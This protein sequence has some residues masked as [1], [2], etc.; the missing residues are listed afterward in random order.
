MYKAPDKMAERIFHL[1]L[2]ILFWITG[3]DYTVVKK[4]S[5]DQCQAFVS[6][7]RGGT[8]SPIPG[9]P[10]HPRIHEDINDRKILELTY[11][12]I[13]L[14]TGE[15]PIRCQDV[16]VY[17][18][19]EEWDYLEGHKDL[20]KDVMMEVPQ[21]RTSPVLSSERT[22]PERC[23]RP[24]LPLDHQDE[25]LNHNNAPDIIIKVEDMDVWGEEWCKEGIPTDNRFD[26]LTTISEKHLISTNFKEEDSDITQY[27][28][29]EHG[30]FSHETSALHN[31]DLQSKALGQVLSSHLSQTVKEKETRIV[32]SQRSHKGEKP[33]VCSECGKCFRHKSYLVIHERIHT[34]EKPYSCLE[35]GK[36]FIQ[37]SHLDKH[38]KSHTGEKPFLCSECGKCFNHKTNLVLH[39][40]IHTGEK[41][42]SCLECGKCFTDQSNLG[43]HQRSHKGEKPY[44]C[45]E[46]SKCF[47]QKSDLL[48]HQR[49]HTGEKPFSCPECGKCFT[50]QSNLIKHERGH[51]EVKPFSCSQCGKYFNQKAHY[52]IHERSHTGEKPFSCSECGK[53]FNQKSHLTTHQRSHTGEKPFSCSECG[54]CFTR[55][56]IL[57]KH[58]KIHMGKYSL[59]N[60]IFLTDPSGMDKDRDKIAERILQLTLEILF[61][62][63]GEDYTV[64]KKNSSDRCQAPVCEGWRG[65]MS[66]IPGSPPHPQIHEV[67]DDQKILELTY[68]MIELLTGEVPIRCQDVTVHFSM[69]EWE[70][71]EGHKDRYKDV[72]MEVHQ[73]RMS[74]V[75]SAKRTTPERSPHPL[76]P[77]DHQFSD[78]EEDLDHSPILKIKIEE[79]DLWGDEE[80]KEEIPTDNCL[81][82]LSTSLEKHLISLDF[83]E[84]DSGIT[85][86]AHEE[87]VVFPDFDSATHNKN[88]PSDSFNQVLSSHLSQTVKENEIHRGGV[89][90]QRLHKRE[91]LFI[92]SECGKWFHQMSDLVRH[93]R[94]HAR[95]KPY[96]CSECQKCFYQKSH[97]VT[98]QRS[99][100]GEKPYS[101]SECDKCF[102]HKSNLVRH[103][104]I[105]TGVKP[106]TCSECGK[107]FADQSNLGKHER[108]HKGEKPYSCFECS[109]CFMHKSDLRIHQRTHTGEKP[110]SCTVCGKCFA[111]QSDRIKH[112]RSHKDGKLYSCLECG[113]YFS[114]K[115]HFSIHKRSHTGEKPYPCSECGKY[116]FQK[117]H[118]TTHQ[119]S[120]TGEKPFSCSECERC[121]SR[122]SILLK[123]QKSHKGK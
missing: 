2:D 30:I 46:C 86:Y 9:S 47:I 90:Q 20:Y 58:Q 60:V 110:Y 10:P 62:L 92:C 72:M 3:E 5:N 83:K 119:R 116:F 94:S 80:C 118:L 123:H 49:T 27:T 18:S 35:C 39:Q 88:L 43:K 107:R 32:D 13:E 71:L 29:E 6:Q 41:P 67:I 11:K 74:P 84:E 38:E 33:F 108:S 120:H 40:R 114:Q 7:G 93:E 59:Y 103:Q 99:H 66:P 55:K 97:L 75:L 53:Y 56:S 109:K 115:A 37:K 122:K 95:E 73:P 34:G 51:K 112:E 4:T 16:T 61:R 15:V 69:E 77:L 63:T 89:A 54:K 121:F 28:H 22:T 14:L 52:I 50:D 82:D 24:L 42:Y 64:V 1:T 76:L 117:S 91:K 79:I 111:Q 78:E 98:H 106:Y 81:D 101:C 12:M 70:Y 105:H 100:T 36:C 26:D 19:M 17:F 48:V 87:H 23:P 57:L 96:S 85:Q 31:K 45:L 68:K 104:R 65:T 44:S 25:D 8:L 21:S 113:K 102:N